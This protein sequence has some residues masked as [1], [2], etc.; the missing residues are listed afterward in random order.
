MHEGTPFVPGSIPGDAEGLVA[1]VTSSQRRPQLRVIPGEGRGRAAVVRLDSR[2]TPP[3]RSRPTPIGV[4][5]ASAIGVV[6]GLSWC[7]LL[8]FVG[9]QLRTPFGDGGAFAAVLAIQL[10]ATAAAIA[11]LKSRANLLAVLARGGRAGTARV[12]AD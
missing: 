12:V 10:G 8:A 11:C 2:R 5:A 3:R 4:A 1:Q 7:A 9:W 6:I